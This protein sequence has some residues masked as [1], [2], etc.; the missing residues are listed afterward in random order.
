MTKEGMRLPRRRR[1]LRWCLLWVPLGA[2]VVGGAW[3][4]IHAYGTRWE[5]RLAA[6][7]YDLRLRG[8]LTPA[9]EADLRDSHHQWAEIDDVVH[10]AS[11]RFALESG[12]AP[13]AEPGP[14]AGLARAGSDRREGYDLRFNLAFWGV[15]GGLVGFCIG[16]FRRMRFGG[17]LALLTMVVY[18]PA[19]VGTF[20]AVD[21]V[22]RGPTAE[23]LFEIVRPWNLFV[24]L[25]APSPA[26]AATEP[27]FVFGF[28]RLVLNLLAA[29]VLAWL[30]GSILAAPFRL[31]MRAPRREGGR[32]HR[33]Q[34]DVK[35]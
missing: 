4:G 11:R 10:V 25:L 30:V 32:V 15:Y 24:G 28:D 23:H 19:Y 9:D 16:A 35:E 29:M 21:A 12:A 5:G 2:V 17:K 22:T 8:A 34:A 14:P 18:V 1:T 26:V 33:V 7:E 3:F 20:V 31:A 13:L 27:A 6:R